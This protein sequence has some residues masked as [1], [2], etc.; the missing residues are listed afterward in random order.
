MGFN[1]E[2]Q[3]AQR[4]RIQLS[5]PHAAEIEFELSVSVSEVFS[6]SLCLCVEPTVDR[7]TQRFTAGVLFCKLDTKK[8]AAATAA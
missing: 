2:T 3:R 7:Y 8:E 4:L 1:A 6:A 5:L